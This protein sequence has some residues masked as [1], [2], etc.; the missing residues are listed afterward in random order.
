L[1]REKKIGMEQSPSS[2]TNSRSSSQDILASLEAKTGH[3]I[4]I[5]PSMVIILSQFNPVAGQGSRTV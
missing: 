3:R 1:R 4:H 5:T 2:E